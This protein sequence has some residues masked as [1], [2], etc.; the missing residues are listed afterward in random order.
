[1]LAKLQ[2]ELSDKVAKSLVKVADDGIEKQ[3]ITTW[4]FGQLPRSYTSKRGQFEVKAYPALVAAKGSVEIKL[5]DSEEQAQ[6]ATR[7]GMRK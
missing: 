1:D 3:N 2:E 5:F 7:L 4:D 6:V